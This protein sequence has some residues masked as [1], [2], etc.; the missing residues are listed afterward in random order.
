M[1]IC[2]SNLSSTVS[3]EELKDL[4]SPYGEVKLAE[5][6]NDVFTGKCRGF[7]Y[8][9]MEDEAAAQKAIDELSGSK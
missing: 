9:E 5:V 1:N 6:M 4:F 8:V 7:G 2:I 3:H